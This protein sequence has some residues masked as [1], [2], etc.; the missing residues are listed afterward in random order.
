MRYLPKPS[1]SNHRP[2][3]PGANPGAPGETDTWFTSIVRGWSTGAEDAVTGYTVAR[4][5]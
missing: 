5:T 4:Y 1:G 3:M 2:G